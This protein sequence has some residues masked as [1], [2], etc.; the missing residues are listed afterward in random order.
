[1]QAVQDQMEY[2]KNGWQKE[3]GKRQRDPRWFY[4]VG[5]TF[6]LIPR[7][8]NLPLFGEGKGIE[9]LSDTKAVTAK[10]SVLGEQA[11]AGALDKYL[12]DCQAIYD[13]AQTAR[14]A[15]KKA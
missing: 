10:L 1:M 14:T 15:K 11:Q 7:Y 12:Q 3:E 8:G 6:T 9:G 13:K 2:A 5:D 4:P